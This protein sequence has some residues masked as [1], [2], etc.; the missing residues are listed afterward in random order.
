MN[1][2]LNKDKFLSIDDAFSVLKEDNMNKAACEKKKKS[3]EGCFKGKFSV[4]LIDADPKLPLFIM[5]VFP[6]M[7]TVMKIITAVSSN[8]EKK[9]SV[10]RK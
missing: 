3:L 1:F 8:D 6:E 4:R 2:N 10:V 7:D 9:E 5:S